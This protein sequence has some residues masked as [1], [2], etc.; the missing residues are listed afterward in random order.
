MQ[1]G[2]VCCPT[3]DHIRLLEISNIEVFMKLRQTLNLF[4]A[5]S[6]LFAAQPVMAGSSL[7]AAFD[8]QGDFVT[9][10]RGNCVRTKWM[11]GDDPCNPTP[12]PPPPAPKPVVKK[13]IPQAVVSQD[14]RTVHFDFDSAKLDSRATNKLDNLI[15]IVNS[16]TRI[17]EVDVK[18]YT[19]QI[20]SKAYNDKLSDK[21]AKAVID[22]MA[23]RM[24]IA[25]GMA[26]VR[27]LGKA[28]A[29][30]ECKKLS[31]KERVSCMRKERRVETIFKYE[32][33]K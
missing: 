32:H 19:D 33:M 26:D 1:S 7:E 14:N 21:R 12:P 6:M 24:R 3:G 2:Y 20:G 13:Y 27:G 5:A 25:P 16:S 22:Y 11:A 17:I 28:E 9:D 4:A 10:M 23:P 29:I 30:E 31:Y 15:N 18:G 8:E